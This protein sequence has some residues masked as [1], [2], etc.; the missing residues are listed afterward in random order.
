MQK[1]LKKYRKNKGIPLLLMRLDLA[2]GFYEPAMMK[3]NDI[4]AIGDWFASMNYPLP[5][6]NAYMVGIVEIA[7]FVLLFLGLGTRLISIPLI[8]VMFVAIFTVHFANG[9][10]QLAMALRFHYTI[11]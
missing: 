5:L 4:N 9:F 8:V 3:W 1:H 2:Y 11:C 10:L 7:G 6:V